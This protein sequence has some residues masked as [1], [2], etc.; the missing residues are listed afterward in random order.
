MFP[1]NFEL[2]SLC[3]VLGYLDCSGGR[4]QW[5]HFNELHDTISN[6]PFLVTEQGSLW[7]SFTNKDI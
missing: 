5:K 1:F 3:G 6:N 4:Y 7:C 2:D